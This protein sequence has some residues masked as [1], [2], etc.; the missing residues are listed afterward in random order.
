M[1]SLFAEKYGLTQEEAE[2]QVAFYVGVYGGSEIDSVFVRND[3]PLDLEMTTHEFVH[4]AAFLGAKALGEEQLDYQIF[5]LFGYPLEKRLQLKQN[6]SESS[7]LELQEIYELRR[8]L[9]EG[10]TQ[11]STREMGRMALEQGQQEL[12]VDDPNVY[13]FEVVAVDFL[14]E[15]LVEFYSFTEDKARSFILDIALSGDLSNLKKVVGTGLPSLLALAHDCYV[16]ETLEE[17][18]KQGEFK[19]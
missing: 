3:L 5:N 9:V 1:A 10:L 14:Q 13:R 11:W 18:I 19:E 17:M 7:A 4:R 2:A 16:K 12:F 15:K 8:V 6:V